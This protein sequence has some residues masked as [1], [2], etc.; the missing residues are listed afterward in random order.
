MYEVDEITDSAK[1]EIN[2]AVME[3]FSRV[4][5]RIPVTQDSVPSSHDNSGEQD[6]E[7]PQ[8]DVDPKLKKLY[9]KIALETHPDKLNE[10][11]DDFNFKKEK[12]IEATEAV[13]TNNHEKLIQIAIELDLE[14]DIEFEKQV[15]MMSKTVKS[16]E[17]KIN[18][19]KKTAYYAWGTCNDNVVKK[20]ILTH[21]LNNLGI[22]SSDQDLDIILLW[23][24]NDSL[25]GTS[26]KSRDPARPLNVDVW[27]PG[28]RPPKRKIKRS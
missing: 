12:Y 10:E 1:R 19:M 8:Q 2:L 7:A 26:Y 18:V 24:A 21:S 20:T 4:G 23:L 27:R 22:K 15:E 11:D 9:R 28:T 14:I 16:L 6:A 3:I 5:K 13:K 25:H 17:E